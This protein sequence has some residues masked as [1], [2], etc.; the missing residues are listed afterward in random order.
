MKVNMLNKCFLLG[1]FFV[2]CTMNTSC[3]Q[4]NTGRNNLQEAANIREVGVVHSNP[5]DFTY[6]AENTVNAVVHIR[7]EMQQKSSL[8][9][10]FFDS[11]PF[12]G[13]FQSR[14]YQAYGSGVIIAEDGYII[15]NNHVV[16]GA[17]KITVTLN[18]KR[19]YEAAVV[20]MDEKN[21]LALL[22]VE[23]KGMKAVP[24]GNS[25]NVRIGE[26]VLAVGNP[27]N[28]TSTVTAG[29]V[30]AKARNLNI[31]GGNTTVSSFIQT[32]AAVNSGNSGG[33]LVNTAGELIGINAAI[34]SNTGSFAGYSFAIPVNIVKKVVDDLMKY[35]RVQ[36][37]YLGAS[38]AEMDGKKADEMHL[39]SAKGIQVFKIEPNKAADKAGIKEGD[40]L[41]AI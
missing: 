31:L 19:E 14:E 1:A 41:L 26:W 29:I 13:L 15:T 32:D 25:D 37:V 11:N 28:L 21:D 30:S 20:G 16:E 22:K 33:A 4:R 7:A 27:F 2:F 24:Y 36:R 34:A 12:S 5:I 35:G 23:A 38:F 8:F 10:L 6:A 18:D 3:G 9:D 39:A 17:T 40:I